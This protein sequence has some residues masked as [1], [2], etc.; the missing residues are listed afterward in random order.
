[1]KLPVFHRTGEVYTEELD[2]EEPGRETEANELARDLHK[3]ILEKASFIKTR[4]VETLDPIEKEALEDWD[5]QA[6]LFPP[7]PYDPMKNAEYKMKRYVT[8][9]PGLSK[10]E[11]KVWRQEWSNKIPRV[12]DP[13]DPDFIGGNDPA[14]QAKAK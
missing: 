12:Y 9:P 11:R 3:H 14:A 4:A 7:D 2:P 6:K 13:T 10:S 8:P 1:M 5:L